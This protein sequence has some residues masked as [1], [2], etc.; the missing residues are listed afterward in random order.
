M[1]E[2]N[3]FFGSILLNNRY[4]V[5]GFVTAG[6]DVVDPRLGIWRY[7]VIR[8][9]VLDVLDEGLVFGCPFRDS[10]MHEELAAAQDGRSVRTNTRCTAGFLV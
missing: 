7:V 4:L 1:A 3:Q 10:H 9:E 5:I 8:G 2:R 6:A